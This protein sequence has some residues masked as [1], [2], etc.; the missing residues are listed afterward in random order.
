MRMQTDVPLHPVTPV[1]DVAL[2]LTDLPPGKIFS[3]TIQEVLPENTYKAL[4]AGRQ[5]TLALPQGAKAGDVLELVVIDR[6]PR[7]IVAQL[8]NPAGEAATGKAYE[9]TK[10]STAGQLI[11]SL[12]ARDG[13]A[14][15]SVALGRGQALLAQV[16]TDAKQLAATLAPQ[17]AKAVSESGLFYESHQVQWATGRRPMVDLLNEPQGKFSTPDILANNMADTGLSNLT[18]ASPNRGAETSARASASGGALSLLQNLFGIDSG[19]APTAQ[20][21]PKTPNPLQTLPDELRPIV[22]Q[23]LDAVATQRMAWHGDVWPQQPLQ[24]KIE[25]DGKSGQQRGDKSDANWTSSLRLTTPRLGEIDA[26][27]SLTATG[28][29]IAINTSSESSAIDLRNAIPALEES[30]V[31]AGIQLLSLKI[32]PAHKKPDDERHE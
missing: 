10:L 17:L 8:A 14:P 25:R 22:Q 27:L 29:R 4:V 26:R 19:Q 24:W 21:S 12:L 11:G 9:F 16:P 20:E 23:Q 28:I 15:A 32:V 7:V 18:E 5:L 30:M 2:D 31:A 1:S 6:S 3:A 13:Q